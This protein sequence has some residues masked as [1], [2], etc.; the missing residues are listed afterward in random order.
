MF[1]IVSYLSICFRNIFL[2]NRKLF[3]QNI[4]F[5]M[6]ISYLII[7]ICD[8]QY[9]KRTLSAYPSTRRCVCLSIILPAFENTSNHF[10]SFCYCSLI[11]FKSRLEDHCITDFS[12]YVRVCDMSSFIRTVCSNNIINIATI[13]L[14]GCYRICCFH[15]FASF[16]FTLP[17]FI[18]Y[19][20]EFMWHFLQ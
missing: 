18:S 16:C 20:V 15:Y 10:Y 5:S 19:F 11:G 1:S 14:F 9:T 7:Y 8:V 12:M 2:K 4:P 6:A 17:F 13:F 3:P